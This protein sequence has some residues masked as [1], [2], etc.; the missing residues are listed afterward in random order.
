MTSSYPPMP[1]SVRARVERRLDQVARWLLEQEEADEI[2]A[3]RA[4]LDEAADAAAAASSR[5][6]KAG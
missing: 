3:C 1:P 2:A 6:S 5:S 4:Q